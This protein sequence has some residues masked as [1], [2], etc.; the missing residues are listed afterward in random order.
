L[1][2]FQS[3]WKDSQSLRENRFHFY[4][5][6]TQQRAMICLMAGTCLQK[7]VIR[8]VCHCVSIIE[9]IYTS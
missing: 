3:L 7:N 1:M 4:D 9:Y 8:W 6:S 5:G 2:E